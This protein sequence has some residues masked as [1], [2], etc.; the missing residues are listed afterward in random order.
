MHLS[1]LSRLVRNPGG[2]TGICGKGALS[3]LGPNRKLDLVLTRYVC[4]ATD[5]KKKYSHAYLSES[6]S[7]VGR[8]K[9]TRLLKAVESIYC[10]KSQ[11]FLNVKTHIS[12]SSIDFLLL[13]DVTMTY[14]Y[15]YFLDFLVNS[16]LLIVMK[17]A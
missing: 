12:A 15:I 3:H 16:L 17:K 8:K 9:V 2:R 4:N 10:S 1:R 6:T 5:F 13:N 14:I 11:L 7:M